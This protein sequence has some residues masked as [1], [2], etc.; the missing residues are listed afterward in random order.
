MPDAIGRRVRTQGGAPN[1]EHNGLDDPGPEQQ[2]AA[3]KRDRTEPD[4]HATGD[5]DEPD[6]HERCRD[7][8][9]EPRVFDRYIAF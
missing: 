8:P 9:E 2:G 1:T 6:D 4:R 3:N 5:K 7:D